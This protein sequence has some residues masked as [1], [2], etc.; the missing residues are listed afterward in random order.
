MVLIFKTE[1]HNYGQD[2]IIFYQNIAGGF[3]YPVL[4]RFAHCPK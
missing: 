1:T 2:K 3:I 4:N